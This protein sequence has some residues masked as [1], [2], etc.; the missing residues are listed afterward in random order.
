MQRSILGMVAA[1]VLGVAFHAGAQCRMTY[2]ISVYSDGAVN[3]DYSAV[4]GYSSSIDNS[5]L[6]GCG[7]GGYQTTTTVYAPDGLS[8]ANTQGGMTSGVYVP[9]NGRLGTYQVTGRISLYCSC[10][11]L[12]AAGGIAAGVYACPFPDGEVSNPVGWFSGSNYIGAHFM[13]DLKDTGNA[14]PPPG[15]YKERI[16]SEQISDLVD[17]CWFP[18]SE[19]SPLRAPQPSEWSSWEITSV[20]KYGVD[21]VANPT[22]WV[23]NY[24]Q[25]IAEGKAPY[26]QCTETDTQKMAMNG[27]E[28]R[29]GKLY[30]TN[31]IK[32]IVEQNQVTIF[33]GNGHRSGN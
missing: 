19:L 11:G 10:A 8:Y 16:V 2:S 1:A 18:A 9:T 23:R 21:Q 27:C 15:R 7:H 30:Q 14:D 17:G 22:Q 13:M 5:T 3:N 25:Q 26:Q 4:Y 6:C 20:N 24:Q 29:P 33:R 32:V 12:V 31:Q 28:A